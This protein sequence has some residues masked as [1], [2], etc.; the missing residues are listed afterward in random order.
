MTFDITKHRL[1]PKH[2]K[3]SDSEK[4][5]LFGDYHIDIK[6]LPRILKEDSAIAKLNA[7][8]GDI[9]KI[10]RAS[11]TAGTTFYYRVVIEG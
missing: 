6:G 1:V 10:E 5:K 3:L 4:K 2:V 8:P 11:K 9:I 7:K